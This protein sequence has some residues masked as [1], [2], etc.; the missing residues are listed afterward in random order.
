LAN[1][2]AAVDMRLHAAKEKLLAVLNLSDQVAE[3]I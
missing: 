1:D 3:A 2:R